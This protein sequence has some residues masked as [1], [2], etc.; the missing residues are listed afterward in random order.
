MTMF[1]G[2]RVIESLAL[3][4]AGE[5]YEVRRTWRERL[6]SWP[7]RPMKATYTVIPQVP[8][9]GGYQLANGTIMMHPQTL[10]SLRAQLSSPPPEPGEER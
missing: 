9:K 4:E 2:V 1:D 6:L 8:M 3:T 7:W 10:A 5:P